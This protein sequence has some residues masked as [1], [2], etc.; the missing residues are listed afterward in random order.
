MAN[1]PNRQK[2]I[3][4]KEDIKKGTL[5]VVAKAVS[6]VFKNSSN[7]HLTRVDLTKNSYDLNDGSQNFVNIVYQMQSDPEL[8]KLLPRGGRGN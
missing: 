1:I 4:A 5:L 6:S 7:S 8:A 2:G 3:F